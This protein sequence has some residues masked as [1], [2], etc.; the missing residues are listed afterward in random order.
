M[1]RNEKL[2]LEK[3]AKNPGLKDELNNKL[4]EKRKNNPAVREREKRA[5][6]A[7][8]KR[9]PGH[10]TAIV[11]ARYSAK[12]R[13][14]PPWADLDAIQQ[15]YISS[16]EITKTTKIKH[17]VDHIVPLQGERVSGLHI[18]W[19]MQILSKSENSGKS[20]RFNQEDLSQGIN[21]SAEYYRKGW[22]PIQ[23]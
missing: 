5:H 4:R 19:N 23:A 1:I 20:N 13:R 12:K 3:L 9:N 10:C 22:I 2:R 21:L 6:L 8:C 11:M 15:I 17:N 7:W 16:A 14:T 18:H